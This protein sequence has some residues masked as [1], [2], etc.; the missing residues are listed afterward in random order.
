MSVT[1]EVLAMYANR[2]GQA[3]FGEAVTM[4]E[5]GLQAAYFARSS[6]APDALVLAALLH[7][8]GHLLESVPDDIAEWTQDTGH[9]RSGGRWLAARFGP[10]VSAPVRWHVPAKRYLC[11]TDPAYAQQ[12][13]AASII[14]LR[15]QGGPMS[16]AEV[17]AF[18]TEP[19]WREAVRVRGWDDQGK[20]AGL[21]VPGFE[22]YRPL[23][24][25]MVRSDAAPAS[26][27]Q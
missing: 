22:H 19:G 21:A 11:T 8:V 1:D 12:L 14:T 10:E 15:L 9:E 2:G 13:S 5:H 26:A 25:R 18:E 24:D 20:V 17:R 27:R 23:I 3:Y 4:A 16:A 6:G 7:D